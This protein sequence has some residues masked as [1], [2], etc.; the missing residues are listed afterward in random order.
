M[1]EELAADIRKR[2]E[3]LKQERSSWIYHWKDI[4]EH[5]YPR[6][7]RFDIFDR[8]R[9]E[10]RSQKIIDSTATRALNVLAAGMMSGMTSPSR[11]WFNLT[12]RDQEVATQ[13]EVAAW[14]H[15]C[16]QRM[17][18]MFNLSNVY[19]VLH[20]I[21]M[22]LG[23]FGTGAA[24][25][26]PHPTK[27]I[28]LYPV[29]AGEYCIAT[30]AFGV[31][32][33]FYREYQM[34]VRMCVQQ[35]GL[36]NCSQHV[37][38]LYNSKAYDQWITIIH[39]IEPRED[40][41]PRNPTA[42]HMAWRSVYVE[43]KGDNKILRESGYRRFPVLC[44][45]WNVV[46]GDI[47]GHSPAMQSL[48]DIRQLQQEQRDK[49]KAVSFQ[50]NPPLQIPASMSSSARNLLP[51]GV[52]YVNDA[53]GAGIRTAFEVTL[54]IN[55]LRE[56]IVDVRQRIN[57]SFFADMFLMMEGVNKAD[58]TA[59]E[60][61]ERQ[62]EKMLML[63]PVLERLHNELLDPLINISFERMLDQEMLAPWPESMN[64]Q[65][66]SIEFVS[67][68]AQAQ[69]SITTQ[70]TSRFINSMMGI[71][72]A[73]PDVL[74]NFNSDEAVADFADSYGVNPKLIRDAQERDAIRQQ[75]NQQ[76]AQQEQMAMA[77]AG[78][79]TMRTASEIK[80]ESMD[81]ALAAVSG[82]SQ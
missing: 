49:A 23:L 12:L 25:I 10:K 79:E 75:R 7:G 27:G 26:A 45:R 61:A 36:E 44:P 76:Q 43:A 8:N 32:D 67:M 82:Y 42:Q 71:A 37:Q 20:H 58:V 40:R 46:G 41:D 63:G 74:D 5:V 28:W 14:M 22:E 60:V 21:Y 69:K 24:I 81:E 73:I 17:I 51:G 66:M 47:Y 48:G 19:R 77:Q 3:A 31:V 65:D 34:T 57:S 13:G 35:F 16:K 1:N 29:T 53:G 38:N 11:P 56:D 4:A 68:L 30:D 62:E 18:R 78:A 50:S 6:A 52:T 59:T 2:N 64:G 54:D 70:A 55:G 33:T 9:G 72:Q 80:P 15:D 39:A